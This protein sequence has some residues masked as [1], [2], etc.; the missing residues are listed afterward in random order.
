MRTGAGTA[1]TRSIVGTA[2][3][4]DVSNGDGVAGNPT[5]DISPTLFPSPLAGDAN[6]F[7][8]SS[9]A[10]TSSWQALVS[11]DITSALGFTPINKA[12]DSMPSGVFDFTTSSVV[13][14]LNPVGVT[15]VANKQ[16]VDAQISGASNQ[17]SQSS[18]NVYRPSG[19]VGIGTVAPTEALHIEGSLLVDAFS[20][21]IQEGIFFREGY[22][23]SGKYNLSILTE[24]F[25]NT[26]ISPDSLSINAFDGIRLV[27]GT[28]DD[29]GERLRVTKT[30]E[31]GIGVMNPQARLTV[32]TPPTAKVNTRFLLGASNSDAVDVTSLTGDV[33]LDHIVSATYTATAPTTINRA[34]TLKIDGPPA[35]GANVTAGD[36][37]ALWIMNGNSAIGGFLGIGTTSASAPLD[38]LKAGTPYTVD[39]VATYE[40]VALFRSDA[41][42]GV[43]T[44][45]NDTTGVAG[46]AS[47]Q[48]GDDLVLA[49]RTSNL[50]FERVRITD[51]GNVGIGKT[52]PQAKLEV[53]G[54][55][56]IGAGR[57]AKTIGV[58]DYFTMTN[59]T[60]LYIHIRTPFRPAV[61]TNMYHF[62]VEGYS[63]GDSRDIDLTFVGY[64]YTVNPTVIQNPMS[65]DPQGFFA[66]TQYIGSDGHIYLRFKPGNV[67]YCSFRVDSM[68]VGNGRIVYPGELVVTESSA[69]TL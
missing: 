60:A 9:G 24:D 17:W 1:A 7:L 20:A 45:A 8:K 40:T 50:N 62:K 51:T 15:D 63:Y 26:G 2:N 54:G 42:K 12:G 56:V 35:I 58:V 64:S 18:G 22:T 44:F 38:V 49:T 57:G 19:N 30:G 48:S 36:P 66:P 59:S 29:T 53:A 28:N 68:Y 61:H 69:A 67:Y 10:N 37:L 39:G 31:V 34:V 41:G 47:T 16:Y 65:R 13:R 52:N 25:S 3:R 46:I 4:L 43:S 55:A 6:K 33:Y 21:G 23:N 32:T 27:T 5:L 14:V 11:G